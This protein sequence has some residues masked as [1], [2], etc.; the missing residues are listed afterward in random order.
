M[1]TT[2]KP[3]PDGYHSVSPH[4]VTRE[5]AKAI[6]FYK[7]AFE[8]QEIARMPGPDGKSIMHAQIKIGDS[9]VMLNDEFPQMGAFSPQHLNGTPVTIH[10][11]VKNVD[12]VYNRAVQNGAKPLMPPKDMFWGD[13]YGQITDPFGH[14]WSIA[15]HIQDLTPA[16]MAKGAAEAMS[17]MCN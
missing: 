9:M 6:E 13:R 11:Y 5:A 17:K 15:T 1:A 14:R 2:A 16:E 10:L 3:V 7:K 12:E 8:A 4:L